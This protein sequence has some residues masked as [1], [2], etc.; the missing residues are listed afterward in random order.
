M[1]VVIYI[2]KKRISKKA[3][4]AANIKRKQSYN[5]R[6]LCLL[7]LFSL[8]FLLLLIRIGYIQFAK[9]PEYK[10]NAYKQQTTSQILTSKRGTIYDATGMILAISSGVDTVSIN[11]GQ[12]FYANGTAVPKEKLATRFL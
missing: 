3:S 8:C 10:E 11:N 7:S 5:V 4:K 9:G 6:S 1:K 2:G 12:V